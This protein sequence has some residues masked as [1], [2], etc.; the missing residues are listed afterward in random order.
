MNH[1][2]FDDSYDEYPQ[3]DAVITLNCGS[4]RGL[5]EIRDARGSNVYV[6]GKAGH[7]KQ[8]I[9]INVQDQILYSRYMIDQGMD[10][11][12]LH[13]S[14]LKEL[15]EHLN[16]G[17]LRRHGIPTG[18]ETTAQPESGNKRGVGAD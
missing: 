8:T 5:G 11:E 6:N 3:V 10:T 4:H 17:E 9:D 14:Q 1:F 12:D 13:E 2:L 15:Q 16:N 7:V 18:S